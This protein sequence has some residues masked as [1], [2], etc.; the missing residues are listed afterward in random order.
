V[1][2]PGPSYHLPADR[3]RHDPAG[4]SV[5]DTHDTYTE[6]NRYASKENDIHE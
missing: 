3:N 2:L 4:G 6:I 5:K 1:H